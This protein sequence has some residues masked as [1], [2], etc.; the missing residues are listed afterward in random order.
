[1]SNIGDMI[2]A[3]KDVIGAIGFSNYSSHVANYRW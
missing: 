3:I 2:G 1:V